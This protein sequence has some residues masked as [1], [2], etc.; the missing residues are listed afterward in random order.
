M[1]FYCDYKLYRGAPGGVYRVAIALSDLEL[2]SLK[3]EMAI[4]FVGAI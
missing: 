2:S 1:P 3:I 4:P